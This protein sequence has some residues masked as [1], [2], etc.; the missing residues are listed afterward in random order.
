VVY[1]RKSNIENSAYR[2]CEDAR[3]AHW[4]PLQTRLRDTIITATVWSP[5]YLTIH[6]P[7]TAVSM[8]F[9]TQCTVSR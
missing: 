1:G 5:N 4:L 2:F 8:S 7:N 3:Q 9:A 6:W